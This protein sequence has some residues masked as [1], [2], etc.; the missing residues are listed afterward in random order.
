MKN[1][2]SGV[3]ISVVIPILNEGESILQ[4][5]EQLKESLDKIGKSYEVIFIDDGSTDNSFLVLEQLNKINAKIKAIQLRK[6]Y[7]KSTALTVGFKEAKG[8]I[9]FTIDGDLQDDPKELPRFLEKINEG[10]DLVS[11]CKVNR[12]DSL[13]KVLSSKVF[14]FFTSLMSNVKIHDF[15]CGLK[16]YKKEAIEGIKIYG[17]LYRYIPVLVANKGFKIGE[18]KVEHHPRKFGR[19]RFGI[20]RFSHGFFDLLTVLF[21]TK[22]TKKPLHFFGTCGFIISGTGF[23]ICLHLSMLWLTGHRPIG[24][25]PLLLLGVLLLI[26]GAQFI[27]IGL[28]GE[29]VTSSFHN[30]EDSYLI[31]KK[32]L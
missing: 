15:N 11:G 17:E 29:L 22:Y 27:S 10:Y 31:K 1:N 19:S 7:G 4:L 28:V 13:S 2:N 32:I 23:L 21:I 20:E 26:W 12:K 25:R 18:I 30:D 24:N 8:A 16:C 14:N 6:N 5:Y 9:V 3:D